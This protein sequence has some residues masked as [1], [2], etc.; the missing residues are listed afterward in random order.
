MD[1]KP[2]PAKSKAKQKKWG[3]FGFWFSTIKASS[4][5]EFKSAIK[6]LGVNSIEHHARHQDLSKYIKEFLDNETAAKIGKAER[7][8][9][10]E[11]LR[12]KILEILK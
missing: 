12:K 11:A 6:M 2:K 8:L 5:E 9:K 4:L 1:K 7:E 10:G 3:A